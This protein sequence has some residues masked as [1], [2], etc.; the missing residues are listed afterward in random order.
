M[1]TIIYGRR[2]Y[3]KKHLNHTGHAKASQLDMENFNRAMMHQATRA[4]ETVV[5]R[6]GQVG[7]VLKQ[8]K[9]QWFLEAQRVAS[10]VCSK[11]CDVTFDEDGVL[12]FY[13]KAEELFINP[14]FSPFSHWN[15]AMFL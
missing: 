6:I 12:V 11:S 5:Q 2:E 3:A 13:E 4:T 1:F 15:I 10:K 9:K 8:N 14:D 7:D